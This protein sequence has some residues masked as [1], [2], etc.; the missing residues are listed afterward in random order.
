M[1]QLKFFVRIHLPTNINI[2]PVLTRIM[3]RLIVTQFLY[4]AISFPSF[5]DQIARHTTLLDK[6]AQID[7]PDEVCNWLVHFLGAHSHCRPTHS[8]KK[9]PQC[10]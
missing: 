5:R 10:W 9:S 4:L 8:I 6:M 7:M 2:T 1:T 3:E